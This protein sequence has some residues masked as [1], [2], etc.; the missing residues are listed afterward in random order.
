MQNFVRQAVKLFFVLVFIWQGQA[1]AIGLGQPALHS[2]LGQ[3]LNVEVAILMTGD[4]S[5][6]QLIFVIASMETYK[7]FGVEFSHLHHKLIFSIK[8]EVKQREQG[9]KILVISTLQPINEPFVNFILEM[10]SPEGKVI[11]EMSLLLDTP[12]LITTQR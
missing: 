8:Q 7:Q 3:P 5:D 1:F 11:K 12:N 4:Y 2:S 6:E 9:K 10:R